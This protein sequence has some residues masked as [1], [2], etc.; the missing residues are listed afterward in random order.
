M[1]LRATPVIHNGFLTFDQL[2]AVTDVFE[3]LAIKGRIHTE[4]LLETDISVICMS[5][6]QLSPRYAD[7]PSSLR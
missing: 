4:H 6:W 1:L 7:M 2:S 3:S 5:G